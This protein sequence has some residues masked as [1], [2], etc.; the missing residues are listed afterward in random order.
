LNE[1][2]KEA[3]ERASERRQAR[4]RATVEIAHALS[5]LSERAVVAWFDESE[6][7]LIDAALDAETDD[8]RREAVAMAKAFRSVRNF[9]YSTIEAGERA[10]GE[11]KGLEW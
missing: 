2:R 3:G 8:G 9:L 10:K 5:G 11:L 4:L 1:R 7:N 6:R